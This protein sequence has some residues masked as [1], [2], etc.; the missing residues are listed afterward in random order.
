MGKVSNYE[1]YRDRIVTGNMLRDAGNR[2]ALCG[3]ATTSSCGTPLTTAFA[4]T[5]QLP[6]SVKFV[7]FVVATF[8]HSTR[9]GPSNF[10]TITAVEE[11][12]ERNHTEERRKR[13]RT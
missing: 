6:N 3:T 1:V 4:D 2:M 8:D 9:S 13:R 10:A 12:E 5:E 11:T 7:Y